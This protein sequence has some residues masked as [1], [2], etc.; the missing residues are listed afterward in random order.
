MILKFAWFAYVCMNSRDETASERLKTTELQA[1]LSA[2]VQKKLAAEGE[3][4]RL[5]LEMQRLKKQLLWTQEQLSSAKEA[6]SRS[7]KSDLQTT[8]T[9]SRLSP[10]QNTNSEALDQVTSCTFKS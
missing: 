10:V 7:Q 1:E 2:A 8:S 4:E 9:E 3:R 5:E 6:P